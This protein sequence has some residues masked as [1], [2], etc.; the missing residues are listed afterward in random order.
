[1]D[2]L[3][4]GA[5]LLIKENRKMA[6]FKVIA[7]KHRVKTGETTF[8]EHTKGDVF[9]S[10]EDL[11]KIFRDKFERVR[12]GR[13]APKA[14]LEPPEDEDKGDGGNEDNEAQAITLKAVHKGQGRWDVIKVVDGEETEEAVNEEFLKK[15]DAKALAEA[16]YQPEEEGE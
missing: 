3:T 2:P 6:K 11:D 9:S 12:G 8:V 5:F 13:S 16:G 10:N 4:T 14:P 15:D 1:M 7:G